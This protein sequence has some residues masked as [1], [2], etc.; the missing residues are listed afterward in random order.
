MFDLDIIELVC[1]KNYSFVNGSGRS[2]LTKNRKY[3]CVK[4]KH[5]DDPSI[6][7]P[8][9]Y[10]DGSLTRVFYNRMQSNGIPHTCYIWDYFY[11]PAELRSIKL[12]KLKIKIASEERISK[13]FDYGNMPT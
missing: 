5:E 6:W 1:K 8:N 4:L 11:T 7:I 10:G 2:L 12:T 9:D 3:K 13:N